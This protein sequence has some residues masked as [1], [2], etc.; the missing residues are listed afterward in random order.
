MSCL[1]GLVPLTTGPRVYSGGSTHVGYTGFL[2]LM[3]EGRDFLGRR[4][5]DFFAPF[6][7]GCLAHRG[8]LSPSGRKGGGGRERGREGEWRRRR[9]SVT[10]RAVAG[11]TLPGNGGGAR[12]RARG[13]SR[14]KLHA[15]CSHR[16]CLRD[17]CRG[18][19]GEDEKGG[20]SEGLHGGQLQLSEE[21]NALRVRT[22]WKTPN[23]ETFNNQYWLLCTTHINSFTGTCC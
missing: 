19:D 16:R 12:Q 15:P 8:A 14:G 2:R 13:K 17:E 22:D 1:S 23:C 10:K 3:S 4:S 20:S 18:R 5:A 6:F 7:W 21:P 11:N 9:T